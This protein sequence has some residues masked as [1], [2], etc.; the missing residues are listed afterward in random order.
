MTPLLS[1]AANITPAQYVGNSLWGALVVP[2]LAAQYGVQNGQVPTNLLYNGNGV[3]ITGPIY[4][5]I[6]EFSFVIEVGAG[7]TAGRTSPMVLCLD[8]NWHYGSGA[9]IT[10]AAGSTY[11]GSF[12]AGASVVVGGTNYRCPPVLGVAILAYNALAGGNI[13]Y[14]E[15]SAR[16][17]EIDPGLIYGTRLGALIQ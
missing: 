7:V 9:G 3:P 11:M 16:V 12:G 13:N 2:E 14:L 8:G 10:F 4:R 17:R 15:Q 5:A 1:Y 6:V